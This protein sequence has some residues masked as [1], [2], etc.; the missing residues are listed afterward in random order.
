[1]KTGLSPSIEFRHAQAADTDEIF[2]IYRSWIGAPYCA[3]SDEYPTRDFIGFDLAAN[4]IYCLA[5]AGRILAVGTVRY[6]P[7]HDTAAPWQSRNPIDLMR[8]ATLRDYHSRGL[9]R[10]LL[11]HLI[12]ASRR[13]GH[14]GMRILV[15]QK[16]LPALK[17]Y[18]NAGAVRRGEIFLYDT[19]W[20]CDEI[21]YV[22]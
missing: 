9:G 16:N 3:W 13:S 8:I 21:I 14:D 7:E 5:D 4:A 2:A 18:Q 6:W 19:A 1:M 17:L 10:L 20:F 22:E 12:E 11:D 15:A